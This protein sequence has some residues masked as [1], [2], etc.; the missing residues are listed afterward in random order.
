MKMKN[1]GFTLIEVMAVV[2]IMAIF[3]LGVFYFESGSFKIYSHEKEQADLQF[4]CKTAVTE[5]SNDIKKAKQSKYSV[6]TETD[7]SKDNRFSTLFDGLEGNYKPVVYIE[8]V[9]G[10]NCIYAK[11]TDALGNIN[12]VKFK[13]KANSFSLQKD[14]SGNVESG[15]RIL[16]YNEKD[17]P[18][19]LSND[20]FDYEIEHL[21]IPANWSYKFIYEESGKFYLV[22]NIKGGS[23]TF[24]IQLDEKANYIS[25]EKESE[26]VVAKNLKDFSVN[27]TYDKNNDKN[28]YENNAYNIAITLGSKKYPNIEKNY[29]MCVSKIK[30]ERDD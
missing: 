3:S 20:K 12:I 26:K 24:E 25:L 17:Y 7:F 4:D 16:D 23:D 10:T 19:Q 5:I 28:N 11:R 21:N 30:Y 29:A 6:I 8:G 18:Q 27:P 9:D 22:Y 13:I 2:A 14:A 1:R 15:S